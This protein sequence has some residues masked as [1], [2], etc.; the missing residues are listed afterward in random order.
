MLRGW[1]YT[2][3]ALGLVC[4]SGAR[5]QAAAPRFAWKT[6][7]VLVYRVEH[8]TTATEIEDKNTEENK[9]KLLLT[10][11]WKVIDVDDSGVA[12]LQLWLSAMSQEITTPK[13]EV[14]AF[15]SENPDKGN[16]QL[17]EQLSQYV[18]KTLAVLR[19]DNK[20]RVVEVKDS[21]FGPASRFERELPFVITLPDEA[22]QPG[23]AWERTFTLTMDPPQGTGEKYDA[24]QKYGCKKVNETETVVHV[25]TS[26]KTLP[27]ALADQIPLLGMQPEGEV[28]FDIT[29][30]RV[31][32]VSLKIDKQLKDHQGEGSSYHL[33]SS[34]IEELVQTNK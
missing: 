22:P 19:V 11:C 33:Q 28:L 13:G 31:R 14:M 34:Y 10:K 20:G 5:A 16:P 15:D 9:T 30:G 7:Q 4:S 17:R 8:I 26:F 12:T 27:M 29:T 23:S 1:T 2:L 25:S 32:K 21:K 6:G 3:F 18:N 24:V